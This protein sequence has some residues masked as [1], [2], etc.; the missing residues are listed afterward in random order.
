MS[1]ASSSSVP[2]PIPVVDDSRIND[3]MESWL[4]RKP[5]NQISTTK[6]HVKIEKRWFYKGEG[7]WGPHTQTICNKGL[8]LTKYLTTG[9][10]IYK[11]D[12]SKFVY[13]IISSP[14]CRYN[15]WEVNF[16]LMTFKSGDYEDGDSD[17][18]YIISFDDEKKYNV[19]W[20]DKFN[21]YIKTHFNN[22]ESSLMLPID[23]K[24]PYIATDLKSD[25]EEFNFIKKYIKEHSNPL[26]NKIFKITNIKSI[27][28]PKIARM[29]AFEKEIIGN[30]QE[31]ILMHTSS[32]QEESVLSGGLD[33]RY[34]QSVVCGN[35]IYVSDS[36]DGCVYCIEQ[37]SKLRKIYIVRCL[38]GNIEEIGKPSARVKPSPTYHSVQYQEINPLGEIFSKINSFCLY[39]NAQVFITH[40][41]DFETEMMGDL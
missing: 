35:G 14:N 39:S 40:V 34:P 26:S 23:K 18:L 11:K 27:L 31:G 6:P 2:S 9:Y 38:L 22:I 37:Y 8:S 30:S 15:N 29:Y 10:E 12:P 4:G 17:G 3:M 21:K 13:K 41:V 7:R 5:T 19:S 25:S 33:M 28:H 32:G 20:N 1:S 36:F 24:K 16:E